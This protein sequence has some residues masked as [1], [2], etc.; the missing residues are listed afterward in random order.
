MAVL[1]YSQWVAYGT[2]QILPNPVHDI[3]GTSSLAVPRQKGPGRIGEDQ[4]KYCGMFTRESNQD[5][6]FLCLVSRRGQNAV[7]WQPDLLK[8][9]TGALLRDGL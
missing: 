2:S 3:R 9:R 1:F 6:K 8:S 7:V 5:A 4:K